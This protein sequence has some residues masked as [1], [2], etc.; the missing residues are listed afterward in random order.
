MNFSCGYAFD[1]QTQT[2]NSITQV[3]FKSN[4]KNGTYFTWNSTPPSPPLPRN[5]KTTLP[6]FKRTLNLQND[7]AKN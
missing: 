2:L 7:K 1:S 4:K 6:F 3:T 5:N